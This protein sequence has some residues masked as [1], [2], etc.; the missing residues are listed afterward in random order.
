[1]KVQSLGFNSYAYRQ[2]GKKVLNEQVFTSMY[3]YIL[4]K[5]L[6]L[7][8]TKTLLEELTLMVTVNSA[9]YCRLPVQK[10]SFEIL[11]IQKY[12]VFQFQIPG[13]WGK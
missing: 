7:A 5:T 2:N 9:K 3:V 10:Y 1:M 8:N 13:H 4:I 6:I 12:P 11:Q